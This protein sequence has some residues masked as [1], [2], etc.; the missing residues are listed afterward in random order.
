MITYLKIV[1]FNCIIFHSTK[2]N[3]RLVLRS[4]AL[5]HIY[6]LSVNF[7]INCENNDPIIYQTTCNL[8]DTTKLVI[9]ENER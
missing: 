5:G 4:T 7:I 9:F 8:N 2:V 1:H 3:A 6:Y